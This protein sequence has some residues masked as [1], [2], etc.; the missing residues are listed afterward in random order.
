MCTL[1]RV[2]RVSHTQN[3][4][5]CGAGV[6]RLESGQSW[7]WISGSYCLTWSAFL[8][9]KMGTESFSLGY[10][11][12][13]R[14]LKRLC[15][16]APRVMSLWQEWTETSLGSSEHRPLPGTVVSGHKAPSQDPSVRRKYWLLCSM[17]GAWSRVTN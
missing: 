13:Q 2:S 4:R 15:N 6:K 10:C 3:P 12:L 7:L 8:I 1:G 5:L 11:R 14:G 16:I 9:F 17:L